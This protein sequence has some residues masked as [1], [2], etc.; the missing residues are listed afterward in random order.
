MKINQI[1][2]S[3]TAGSIATVEGG[4]GQTQY[5]NP[6]IY[7]LTSGESM[8]KGKKTK[9]KFANSLNEGKIKELMM[10]LDNPPEGLS[11]EEFKK[12][13]KMTKQE[14]R[15]MMKV[16]EQEVNEADLILVPGQGHRMKPGFIARDMDRTDR[17]IEMA[18]GDLYQAAKNAKMIYDMIKDIPEERGL[19]GW[20]QEKITKAADYLNT[21]REYIEQK[22][23]ANENGGVIA[24]FG[25]AETAEKVL[26]DGMKNLKA[27]H[28]AIEKGGDALFTFNGK[29]KDV[30]SE[31]L[32]ALRGTYTASL[33]NDRQ[34]DMLNI[35]GDENKFNR[36]MQ[37]L[38]D[39]LF[40][41]YR[42]VSERK[43]NPYAIGMAQ[44]MRATGDEPPLEKSTIVKAHDIARSI[45]RGG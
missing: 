35:L 8:L 44:A 6:S 45:Q 34:Q 29:F 17:E 38:D 2:E 18:S 28:A 13:Y 15:K 42:D 33:K 5:R 3:T 26:N 36:L 43:K 41:K 12:V 11:N 40:A 21:V 27:I 7:G 39:E 30:P 23:M 16:N 19:E 31:Y 32:R 10:D 4:Q 1:T 22:R 37:R 25:I 24:G 14:A 9:K 20:V